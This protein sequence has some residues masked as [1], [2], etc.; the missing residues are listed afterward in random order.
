MEALKKGSKEDRM[1]KIL[2][3]FSAHEENETPEEEANESPEFQE[4]EDKLGV[5]KHKTW[6]PGVM[7]NS[8]N[9]KIGGDEGIKD[10]SN[11]DGHDRPR[12]FGKSGINIHLHIGAKK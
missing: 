10:M 7:G 4:M 12:L 11:E 8:Y 1:K 2:E 9:A 3:M 5:E 6:V